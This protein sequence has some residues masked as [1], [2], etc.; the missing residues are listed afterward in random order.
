MTPETRFNVMLRRVG[1]LA[2]F[3]LFK[4]TQLLKGN[5]MDPVTAIF[6]FLATPAGQNVVE[7][8]RKVDASFVTL[9]SGLVKKVHD[10]A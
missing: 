6:A 10:K 2:Q 1:R 3:E 9:I 5:P 4:L 7:D 8:I